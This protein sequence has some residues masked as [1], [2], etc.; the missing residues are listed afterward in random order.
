MGGLKVIQSLM[1]DRTPMRAV[2]QFTVYLGKVATVEHPFHVIENLC[3][4]KKVRYKGLAKSEAQLFS[5]V[6]TG[7]SCHRQ[8]AVEALQARGAS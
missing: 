7:Q 1:Y 6:R 4:H 3:K 2:R 5:C 8:E